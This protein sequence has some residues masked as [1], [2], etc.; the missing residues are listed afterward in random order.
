MPA[1]W[2][3]D[4]LPPDD[5]RRSL[6]PFAQGRSYGDSCLND[7]G[8]LIDT[9]ALDRFVHF[10]RDSGVLRCEAGVTLDAILELAMPHGWFLPVTPGTRYVS[11]GG[12]IANDVHGKN[13]HVVGTFGRH[14]RALEL[15]RSDG[16]RIVCGP[17]RNTKWF[18]ATVAGLGLTGLITWAEVQ[19]RPIANMLMHVE[20][21]PFGDLAEFFALARESEPNYEY[22][23]AWVD[24]ASR[25]RGLG[26]G[27][28]MRGNH[29]AA[30]AGHKL[31]LSS[32]WSLVLPVDLPGMIL[33]RATVRTFNTLY[34]F[35]Q[36]RRPAERFMHYEP[37]F[38]P[39]DSIRHW[40]RLYG[41]RGFFQY[42]CVVPDKDPAAMNHILRTIGDS[43]EGSF[44]SVLKTFGAVK[45]PGM[46]SFPRKGV[47]LALDFSNRGERTLQLLERLDRI[48]REAGGAVYPAKD[49][50][51]S[52][53]SFQSYY[54]Q[55]RAFSR[56]VDPRFSS[57]FWRRV[58]SEITEDSHETS[59]DFGG[60]IGNR[61]GSRQA[62]RRSG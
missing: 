61:A 43:G 31:T 17:Q 11:I 37:F 59:T 10:D 42:Q 54:P 3:C 57:S 56:F 8:M 33:N 15:L 1:F 21:M 22:T 24:C 28:F 44:L 27:V 46:L 25:G 14:V 16:Q 18:Q 30:D 41:R 45:S 23:V 26:R 39:L 49:A 20:R 9:R 36:T 52:A 35:A 48:T 12:A 7:R 58:A 13:H 60:H 38:Y 34:R 51:M 62:V 19:L 40:N 53:R 6:L 29:A 47:T 2:R 4:D 32:R 55:W 50:R 5:G